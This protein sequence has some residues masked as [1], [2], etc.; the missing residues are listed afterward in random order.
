MSA[1]ARALLLAALSGLTA[2]Q[3]IAPTDVAVYD[4]RTETLH[5]PLGIDVRRPRLGWKLMASGRDVLQTAYQVQVSEGGSEDFAG[6]LWWDS[7]RVESRE[8]VYV[9][10]AGPALSSRGRYRWR[11]RVW[12]SDGNE[13]G[14]SETAVWE[15]GLLE[16]SDWQARWIRGAWPESTEAS[17]PPHL[18]RRE[19]EIDGPIASARIYATAHG[20]YEIYLNGQRIGDRIFSPGFTSYDQRLQY[21]TYDVTDLVRSGPNVIGGVVADGWY[22]G[23]LGFEG[24]RNVYGT[25]PGLWIQ[26][27]VQ[28]A[29]LGRQVLVSD[30][31]WRARTGPW[32]ASDIYEGETYDARLEEDGWTEAGYNDEGWTR[33]AVGTDESRNLVADM[34]PPVRRIGE[35][36][37]VRIFEAPNGE[38]IADMGQNFVGRVRLRMNGE[39]GRTV[40][41]R[42]GEALG[43]DGNLY[44]ANLRG[45]AQT[46]RY[47]LRGGVGETWEPAFTFHGFRYV[48]LEGFPGG[49]PSPDDVTGIV[50]HSDLETTGSFETSDG[51]LNRLQENIVWS[52]RSNFLDLPTDCP[53]RDERLGWTG[54]VQIFG[55]TACFNM[56]SQAFLTKWLRDLASDQRPDGSVPWVVP[57]VL[58]GG[59]AGT[60]A[61]GDAAVIVPWTLYLHYGDRRVLEEQYPSM[62]AWLAYALAE[63]GRDRI[64]QPDFHFG[65]WLSDPDAV[66]SHALIATA[67]LAH[68]VDLVSQTARVLGLRE[69][70]ARYQALFS[71]IR[72]AFGKAFVTFGGRLRNP[73][74]T[75]YVLALRF[76]L[77]GPL[78][79]AA[80]P[81]ELA[82]DVRERGTRL[83]T[84][85]LG[86]PHINPVLTEVGQVELAYD[87][88]FQEAWPSWLYPLT[89]GATTVWERWDGSR[90]GRF[91][92]PGMNSFNHYALGGVGDWMYQVIGG[93]SPDPAEPGFRHA[94]LRPVPDPRLDYARTRLETRYGPLRVEWE[95]TGGV[96]EVAAEVPPN[97]TG[98]M[99]LPQAGE[100]E[101]TEGDRA[102]DAAPGVR[103]LAR[104][105]ADLL[106]EVG[107]GAYRFRYELPTASGVLHPAPEAA[108]NTPSEESTEGR[109]R[110]A[111]AA[112]QA[113]EI[114]LQKTAGVWYI[115]AFGNTPVPGAGER[116]IAGRG[117]DMPDEDRGMLARSMRIL[118]ENLR[119]SGPVMTAGYTLIAAILVS[120]GIGFALDRWLGT[121]P[122][123]LTGGLLFGV[124]V[125]FFELARIVWRQ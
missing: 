99:R 7:G 42:H 98:T 63:A 97:T 118:Q 4:L 83:S 116:N 68:S 40:R 6:N 122:W 22:R 39:P 8:S 96:L 64:W 19:F 54:D 27:E 47:T 115:G 56:D 14:W 101:V 121:W 3:E 73:T 71:E 67:Y 57:D 69:D 21:Q 85:F 51:R 18:L 29:D 95:R 60:S 50:I 120:G 25:E 48:A 79:G 117:S 2:S 36:R 45:A 17:N 87:L 84:G 110:A 103:S 82:R 90:D 12:T 72:R 62:E 31:D 100:A 5:D 43:E 89:Q 86:T 107:S 111:V 16:D 53:Q 15:M 38:I 23:R 75:A 35:L 78:L 1:A 94:I 24:R 59:N 104:V 114:G 26:L 30:P 58:G 70:A 20:I 11:T 112:R 28:Q 37:P 124:V 44:I 65:D 33:V 34:T 32:I 123:F 106:V 77:A 61:W 91:Q 81:L 80:A 9:A 66:T 88:L 76:G 113:D 10:Y 74:Q 119:N 92:D 13:S 49:A 102:L 41:I 52:Q 108:A 46:D 125:G 93:V 109:T 105:G 55:P